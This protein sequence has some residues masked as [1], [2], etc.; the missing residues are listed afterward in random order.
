MVTVITALIVTLSS[1]AIPGA[2]ERHTHPPGTKA[3][4]LGVVAF[5]NSGAPAAQEP[6]L[7]GLALLHSFEYRGSR[8]GFP[9]GTTG[10]SGLRHG[11]LGR[12]GDL[13]S[14]AL[15][16]G[17]CGGGQASAE[18]SRHP[19]VTH[20]W[21]KRERRGSG[22]TAPRSRPCSPRVICRPA[23]VAL[24]MRCVRSPRRTSDDLD[25]AAFTSLA[26][27]FAEYVGQLPSDQRDCRQS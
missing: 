24:P 5:A 27:M 21:P 1:I 10:R 2:Q 22:R 11:V 13:Q 8:G 14:P 19:R 7:R 17:R 3:A 20:G 25:A 6:F 4:G 9:S 18:P 23:C 12:S 16:R 26:L 15:G